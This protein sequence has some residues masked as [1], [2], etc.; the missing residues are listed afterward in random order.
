MI[1]ISDTTPIISLMKVQRL[2]L[3]E[4][5]YGK[6]LIPKAVY[7]ELT[8]NPSYA[9]EAEMIRTLDYLEVVPIP[10]LRLCVRV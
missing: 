3:L 4:K 5:M 6:I 8:E 10:M 2:E 9:K 1:V 7:R